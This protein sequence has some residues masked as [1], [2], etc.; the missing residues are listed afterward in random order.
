MLLERGIRLGRGLDLLLSRV[1]RLEMRLKTA[2]M[3]NFTLRVNVARFVMES[4]KDNSQH[5][6][7][8]GFPTK[9][10]GRS[11]VKGQSLP[12]YQV[13]SNPLGTAYRDSLVGSLKKCSVEEKVLEISEFVKPNVEWINKS[14]IVRT[15]DLSTLIKLDK[16]L[17]SVV[18]VNVDFIYVGGFYLIFIFDSKEELFYF[19]DE[20]PMVKSWFPWM[21]VWNGQSLP[22]ERIAWLKITGVPLHLL[23]NEVFDSVGRMY[24]KIVHASGM[25]KESYDLTYDLVG[26]LVG[27]G[28]VINDSV[29]LR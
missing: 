7:S 21:E 19:K 23:H 10:N 28:T 20:V 6:K 12:P 18:G 4:G 17:A 22:F 25:C 24:G 14:L 26:V 13:N 15:A 1:L 11:Y 2:W 29:M 16:L 27:E 9:V 3:G 5:E 8:Y